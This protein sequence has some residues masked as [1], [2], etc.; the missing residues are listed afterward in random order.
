MTIC[1]QSGQSQVSRLSGLLSS[2][3][4]NLNYSQ[5]PLRSRH[6]DVEKARGFCIREVV[7]DGLG[8]SPLILTSRDRLNKLDKP[9]KKLRCA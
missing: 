6:S 8:T 3:M 4:D 5:Q 2:R 9:M 7:R 1:L